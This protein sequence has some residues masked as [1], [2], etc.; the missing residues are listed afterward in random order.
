MGEYAELAIDAGLD[1][2][3]D[4]GQEAMRFEQWEA[5]K[6][7]RPLRR[8]RSMATKKST[9]K[10][11]RKP[12][13]KQPTPRASLIGQFELMLQSITET[14]PND[15]TTP[16]VSLAWLP[17]KQHFYGS[18]VRFNGTLAANRY[19]VFK[20]TGENPV[21]VLQALIDAWLKHIAP[22]TRN[23]TEALLK[24]HK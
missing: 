19:V 2:Y 15:P 7:N 4:Y 16:G 10:P 14:Y 5:A 18:I 11:G 21:V 12:V 13:V 22:V 9:R 6:G 24:F 23:A 20:A 17:D 8:G 3:D 1:D